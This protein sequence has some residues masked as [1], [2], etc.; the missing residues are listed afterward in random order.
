MLSSAVNPINGGDSTMPGDY[1]PFLRGRPRGAPLSN[2]TLPADLSMRPRTP[3]PQL[4]AA[5]SAGGLP[6][7][8]PFPQLS[9][10]P[11]AGGLPM[12]T[13]F[14][15]LHM[16]PPRRRSSMRR[17]HM[18]PARHPIRIRRPRRRPL[19]PD[20]VI[21]RRSHG[22][23]SWGRHGVI[24]VPLDNRATLGLR[25]PPKRVLEIERV[26]CHRRR[27]PRCYD[28]EYDYDDPPPPP[29]LAVPQ[30]A[31]M[32]A[33]PVVNVCFP[34]N[35]TNAI[36]TSTLL[37]NLTPEMLNNLPKQTV[38]LE[39]IHIEGSHADNN[40]GFHTVV[41]PAEIINPIDGTLSIIQA[42]PE[43]N[44]NN[45][46]N[47]SN[48]LPPIATSIQPQSLN[49]P[50]VIGTPIASGGLPVRPP[51]AANPLRQRFLEL[52]QRLNTSRTQPQ[53][54][55]S[56]PPI[57]QPA[58]S[59]MSGISPTSNRLNNLPANSLRY[60]P[61]ISEFNPMGNRLNNLPTNPLRN[62]PN[63]GQYS[64]NTG[65]Y[66]SSNITPYQSTN[67]TPYRTSTFTPSS[68]VNNMTY[69][70]PSG[71]PS[72]SSD[73]GPYRPA[74]ITPYT[75]M[76]NRST[77]NPLS[78]PPFSSNLTRYASAGSLASTN[79][80]TTGSPSSS[81]VHRTTG[82]YA[83]TSL[84]ST[85]NQLNYSMPKSILRNGPSASFSNTTYTNLNPP[86]TFSSNG[87]FPKTTRFD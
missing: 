18:L 27:R 66:R 67:I 63:L 5:P 10:G 21:D 58:V 82:N 6:M 7:R 42:N 47:I 34:S 31:P 19:T 49:L 45:I 87:A 72:N 15:N 74:N 17:P 33:N 55:T 81:P 84:S 51:M 57:N 41:F 77:N 35:N 24:R 11:L 43:A 36:A 48:I 75:N 38:H 25:G 54:P 80:F 37:S 28:Y 16:V 69:L 73:L 46:S 50:T 30:P 56:N 64:S 3:F 40:T 78:R 12:R 1:E 29:P 79:T 83:N 9:A 39:P 85:P 26:R 60:P 86:N 53:I 22:H 76:S 61:N 20:I 14:P 68:R 2:S 23:S 62:P 8:T 32:V 70:S 65:P 52:F 13:Q 44:N 71:A 59:N 4:S